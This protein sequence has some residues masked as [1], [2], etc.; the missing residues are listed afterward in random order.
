MKIA[1]D[2]GAVMPTRA[3]NYDAGLDL[4]AKLGGEPV[5]IAPYGGSV[6]IDTGVHIQ[7]PQHFCGLV[8]SRS[9][10]MVNNRILTDG[11]VDANY[12]GSVRV[13]LFNHGMFSYTVKPGDKIAQ[14]VITLCCLPPLEITDHLDGTD[15]GNDGFG[16][17]GR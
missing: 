1:L 6:V 12:T 17:S 4:Y 13:A 16:S 9:G 7:I 11:V 10:L 15:R 5:T 3:H 8:K 14:L 2:T